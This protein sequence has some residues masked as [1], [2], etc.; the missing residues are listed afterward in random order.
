MTL[1]V[2]AG[3]E[4]R[5]TVYDVS[6][7]KVDDKSRELLDKYKDDYPDVYVEHLE[8]YLNEYYPEENFPVA[9]YDADGN[10][11]IREAQVGTY[12][13]VRAIV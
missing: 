4:C 10:Y 6:D 9:M 8:E 5:E 12:C 1:R 3:E 2:I 13:R 11:I 7:L